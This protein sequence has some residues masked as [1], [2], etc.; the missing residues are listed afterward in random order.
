MRGERP[1]L[2]NEDDLCGGAFDGVGLPRTLQVTIGLKW[3]QQRRGGLADRC[4]CSDFVALP[5]GLELM[6]IQRFVHTAG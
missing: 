6:L 2:H 5:Q 4:A 1:K 3:L